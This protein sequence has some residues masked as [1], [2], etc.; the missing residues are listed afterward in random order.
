MKIAA[1]QMKISHTNPKI[2][3]GKVE[4]YIKQA[5]KQKVDVIVFPEDMLTGA[6]FGDH[7]KLLSKKE[8]CNFFQNLAKQYHLDIVPGTYTEKIGDKFYN[9][10][11]YIDYQGKVLATYH[12]INLYLCER[13]QATAGKKVAVFKTRFG[14]AGLAICWDITSPE[15]LR[16]MAKQGVEIVYCPSYWWKEIA[17]TGL[18]LNN[19]AE[20]IKV[21]AI[22]QARTFEN[23]LTFVYAN[24]AGAMKDRGNETDTLIGHS[25]IITPI[26]G[27]VA[28]ANHNR[29]T[30]LV[31]EVDL[32]L[33]K[34]AEKNYLHRGDID[35]LKNI[36]K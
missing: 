33:N 34:E 11:H 14:Q 2:N 35:R 16:A 17:K 24:A 5:A 3:M 32:K 30:M 22:C 25:Q 26:L 27:R 4:N 1:V 7:S 10:T 20:E 19:Q 15:I 12:K 21:D 9:T 23:N 8:F 29:E 18:K 28:F 13:G 31:R 36:L 6:I